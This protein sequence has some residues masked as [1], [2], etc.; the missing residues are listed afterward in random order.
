MFFPRALK[1]ETVL[2]VLF[3]NCNSAK[4]LV[5]F[6]N[7]LKVSVNTTSVIP[8]PTHAL[9]CENKHLQK[10]CPLIFENHGYQR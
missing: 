7:K 5:G 6:G 8:T 4:S 1:M 3:S 10:Q 2:F 9:H